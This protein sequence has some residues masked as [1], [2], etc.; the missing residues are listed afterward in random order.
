M[1]LQANERYVVKLDR[2]GLLEKPD[3]YPIQNIYRHSQ[4]SSEEYSYHRR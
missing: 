3:Y 4:P 1:L 2:A